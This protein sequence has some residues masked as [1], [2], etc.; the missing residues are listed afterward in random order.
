MKPSGLISRF[1]LITAIGYFGCGDDGSTPQPDAGN[2]ADAGNTPDAGPAGESGYRTDLIGSIQLLENGSSGYASGY[3]YART[4]QPGEI[5][6]AREG[7]CTL[8]A[9]EAAGQCEEVC[10]GFCNSQ[11]ECVP[12]PA[13]ASAG[14][15]ML[16][17]LESAFTLVPGDFGYQADSYPEGDLF[18]PG[19]AITATAAGAD[20]PAFEITGT[21][22]A[23]LVHEIPHMVLQDNQDFEISWTP[24][25]GTGEGAARIQLALR[26][27]WHGAPYESMLL[28][29]S[30]D[31][32]SLTIPGGLIAELPS[33]GGI[34]LFPHPSELSRY[35]R[36][37]VTTASGPVE[38][39]IASQAGVSF[40]HN[41]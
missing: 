38:L 18:R 1:L 10:E 37:V 31:D 40:E 6:S 17:G 21:G 12:F 34:S 13:S 22:V 9:H 39:F 32:G 14:T 15:I 8:Y 20:I 28:C 41:P 36:T 29:D 24:A 33:F 16:S 7:E 23:E 5:V 25:A 11:Q 35:S 3:F 19:V 2:A 30:A 27:G 4:P 26:T